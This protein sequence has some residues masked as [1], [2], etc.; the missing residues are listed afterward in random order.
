VILGIYVV[1]L[2]IRLTASRWR[3][4]AF[5]KDKWNPF[6]FIVVTASF[7]PVLR[8]ASMALRLVRLLRIVRIIRFLPELRITLSAIARSFPGVASLAAATALL[9]YIYGMIGWAIFNVHDPKHFG[10]VGQA[11]LTMC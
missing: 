10:N 9:V 1:E 5:A 3:P 4:A 6:D 11:M 8:K 2:M 7:V